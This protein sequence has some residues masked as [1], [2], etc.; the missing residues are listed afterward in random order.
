MIYPHAA[1]EKTTTISAILFCEET[2]V[3]SRTARGELMK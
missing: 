2:P 3:F 1:L